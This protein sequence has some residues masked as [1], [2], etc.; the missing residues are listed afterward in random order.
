MDNEQQLAGNAVGVR[1]VEHVAILTYS[2]LKKMI[3]A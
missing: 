3:S 2:S 1:T